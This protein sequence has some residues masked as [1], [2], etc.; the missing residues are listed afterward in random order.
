[1]KYY[2]DLLGLLATDKLP[3]CDRALYRIVPLYLYFS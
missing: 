2:F 3:Y 1:M